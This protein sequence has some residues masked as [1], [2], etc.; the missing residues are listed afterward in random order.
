MDN[1]NVNITVNDCCFNKCHTSSKSITKIFTTVNDFIELQCCYYL[2]ILTVTN[3][4][5][6]FS[7]DNNVIHFVRRAFI[8]VPLRLC[9]PNNC[10]SHIITITVNSIEAV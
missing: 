8:N 10:S 1:F 2:R 6:L 9:L 7:I 4:Y 5:I 3:T